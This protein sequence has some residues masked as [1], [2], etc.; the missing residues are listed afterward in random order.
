M[1]PPPPHS[2]T[3][4]PDGRR[5]ALLIWGLILIACVYGWLVTVTT[6]FAPGR[7]GPNF[8]ALG[9]DWMAIHDGIRGALHRQFSLIY[10]SDAFTARLNRDY[11]S[12]LSYPL[13]DR[14]WRYP[15]TLP[16]LLAPFGLAPFAVSL[17]LFQA[18]G[19]VLLAFACACA[20]L[21]PARRGLLAVIIL[22]SPAMATNVVLGQCAVWVAAAIIGGALLIRSRPIVAGLILGLLSTKPQFALL[23]P[24]LCLG[25][26][27]AGVRAALGALVSAGALVLASLAVMGPD[28]W[29]GWIR[30]MASPDPLGASGWR[31]AVHLWDNSVA[32]CASLLGA[33]PVVSEAL[34]LGVAVISAVA[35]L[36][37]M[38]RGADPAR[39][40][41]VALVA[42]LLTSPHWTVADE[43]LLT[44]A[45][46][47]GLAA[48]LTGARL[49]ALALVA[50]PVLGP[51]IA[52]PLARL[53]PA[54][55]LAWMVMRAAAPV[56]AAPRA[57]Q[58]VDRVPDPRT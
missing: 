31:R 14:P 40:A 11:A 37:A 52:D 55:L 5:F 24:V 45:A 53:A 13:D 15:P 39:I 30:E 46:G 21:S 20:P 50:L 58:R 10:N 12:R 38:R 6:P 48:G 19:A 44:A 9:T 57:V 29:V 17:I 1:T 22:A 42:T 18:V 47:F 16:V 56:E 43:V 35:L 33:D 2:A 25:A 3:T 51:P 26:G 34:A 32:T 41:E 8:D 28:A 27:R 54:I 36:A 23:V 49:G 4:D 7:L